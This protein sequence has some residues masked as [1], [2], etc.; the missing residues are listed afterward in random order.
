MREKVLTLT[1]KLFELPLLMAIEFEYQ[2]LQ[3][4]VTTI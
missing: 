3:C 2:A 4:H 1:D